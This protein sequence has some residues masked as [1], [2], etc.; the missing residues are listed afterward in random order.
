MEFLQHVF[1]SPVGGVRSSGFLA[2]ACEAHEGHPSQET[3]G[4]GCGDGRGPSLPRH[5]PLESRDVAKSGR[6]P[7]RLRSPELYPRNH[8]ARN[9]D[10]WK[11]SNN[12][13]SREGVRISPPRSVART[14]ISHPPVGTTWKTSDLCCKNPRSRNASQECQFDSSSPT[15]APP[16]MRPR[17]QSAATGESPLGTL[18]VV[19]RRYTFDYPNS[20]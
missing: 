17:R 18:G 4:A 11:G 16:I 10:S 3:G 7:Y 20:I 12:I 8:P 1:P 9:Q 13:R 19:P 15:S 2:P 5:H 14:N 6:D